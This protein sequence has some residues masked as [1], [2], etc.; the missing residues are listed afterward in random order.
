MREI[1]DILARDGHA[2]AERIATMTDIPE[3]TV[4]ERISAWEAAGIIRRYKAVVDWDRYNSA[5][6]TDL[7]ETITAFIDVSLVP[8]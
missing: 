3:E 7:P 1:L 2:T 8:S 5:G 4:R 6:P